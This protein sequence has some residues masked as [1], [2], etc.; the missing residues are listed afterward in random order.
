MILLGRGQHTRRVEHL[1]PLRGQSLGGIPERE[2][3]EQAGES[4][5]AFADVAVRRP[6]PPECPREPE[7]RFGVALRLAPVQRG[8]QVIVLLLQARKPGRLLRTVQLDIG[9]LRELYSVQ[10]LPPVNGARLTALV[11]AL[12]GKLPHRL[13]QRVPRLPVRGLLAAE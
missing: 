4:L 3:C 7:R 10:Y 1:R 13:Q 8:A 11:Q 2:P 12:Q 9:H 5:P 6:E